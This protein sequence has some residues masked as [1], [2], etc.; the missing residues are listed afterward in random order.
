M[1]KASMVR[2]SRK[3][4]CALDFMKGKTLERFLLRQTT[5]KRRRIEW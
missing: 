4:L 2:T 1:G 5:L 3:A